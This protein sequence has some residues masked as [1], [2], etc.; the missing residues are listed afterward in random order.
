LKKSLER[1]KGFEPS[2]PTLARSCSTTELHPHPSDW[3]RYRAGNRQSYAKCRSRMQQPARG[4]KSPDGRL[5][6]IM[7]WNSP[8]RRTRM[9]NLALMGFQTA[10]WQQAGVSRDFHHR[11]GL[12]RPPVK[13]RFHLPRISSASCRSFMSSSERQV[14]GKLRDGRPGGHLAGPE[15]SPGRLQIGLSNAN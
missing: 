10:N 7:G 6:A 1:A 8:E 2:T 5:P 14:A 13:A 3:R 15:P 11:D 12:A 9:I 4:P